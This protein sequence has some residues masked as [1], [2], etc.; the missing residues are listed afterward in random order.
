MAHSTGRFVLGRVLSVAVVV[1]GVTALTWL[2]FLAWLVAGVVVY[3]AYSYRHSIA[4]NPHHD[5][6]TGAEL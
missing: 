5:A 3:F 1:I 2:R 6:K 4:A